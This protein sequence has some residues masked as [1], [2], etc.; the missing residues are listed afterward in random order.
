MILQVSPGCNTFSPAVK[1]TQIVFASDFSH[2][3]LK[4]CLKICILKTKDDI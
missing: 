3:N 4:K 1:C 2:I